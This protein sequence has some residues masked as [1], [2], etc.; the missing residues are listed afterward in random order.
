MLQRHLFCRYTSLLWTFPLP[1]PDPWGNSGWFPHNSS[2]QT[3]AIAPRTTALPFGWIKKT[4]SGTGRWLFAVGSGSS[5]AFLGAPRCFPVSQEWNLCFPACHGRWRTS[6]HWLLRRNG[7]QTGCRA[8]RS[9]V[10]LLH[11][12][13]WWACHPSRVQICRCSIIRPR[14]YRSPSFCV[15]WHTAYQHHPWSS[16]T[17]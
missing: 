7:N 5:E 6:H 16:W 14:R 1:Y 17:Q 9:R 11:L 15:Q 2:R 10:N 4:S 13:C 8:C 12:R 3:M